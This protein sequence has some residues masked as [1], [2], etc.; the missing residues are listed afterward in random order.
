MQK[1]QSFPKITEQIK[2]INEVMKKMYKG[3]Y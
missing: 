3:F 2:R 1:K